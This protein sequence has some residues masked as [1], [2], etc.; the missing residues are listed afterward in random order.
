VLGDYA[1][2]L[3]EAQAGRTCCAGFG[4]ALLAAVEGQRGQAEAAREA[5]QEA[6]ARS[7]LLAR[8]PRAFYALF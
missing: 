7:P 3:P 6:T 5:L 2:K 4:P 1:A 8:D